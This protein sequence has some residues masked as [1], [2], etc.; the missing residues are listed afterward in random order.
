MNH[1]HSDFHNGNSNQFP[2]AVLSLRSPDQD[3]KS[4]GDRV[5]LY[6]YLINSVAINALLPRIMPSF[7]ET[8]K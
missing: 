3:P 1:H 4:V 2:T 8:M 5:S 6:L 7:F